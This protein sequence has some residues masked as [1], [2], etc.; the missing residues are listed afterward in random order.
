MFQVTLLFWT[1]QGELVQKA[2]LT[3][4]NDIGFHIEKRIWRKIGLFN[5]IIVNE[6]WFVGGIMQWKEQIYGQSNWVRPKKITFFNLNI[7]QKH[8]LCFA[9]RPSEQLS[10]FERSPTST[11]TTSTSM[12]S[13]TS[14]SSSLTTFHSAHSFVIRCSKHR[15]AVSLQLLRR[16][17][18]RNKLQYLSSVGASA[19]QV[20]VHRS[21]LAFFIGSKSIKMTSQEGD[22]FCYGTVR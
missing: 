3:C 16:Y 5:S 17:G 20:I 15:L 19:Y 12:L 21:V 8:F 14:S 2:T 18:W 11:T 7:A 13:S 10:G 1:N 4:A 22:T 6:L 9:L